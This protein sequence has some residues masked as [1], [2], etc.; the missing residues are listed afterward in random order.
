MEGFPRCRRCD[1][2]NLVPLSDFGGQGAAIHYKA[3]A[4]TRIGCTSSSL[5][6][7][8][9]EAVHRRADPERRRP[10]RRG[11]APLELAGRTSSSRTA[12]AEPGRFPVST[13]PCR[14]A[15]QLLRAVRQLLSHVVDRFC[16]RGTSEGTAP[17]SIAR[18]FGWRVG[19]GP[20]A[21]G[22]QLLAQLLAGAGPVT[23]I[24][25]SS[26]GAARASGSSSARSRD[27]DLLAH[28]QEEDLPP[29]RSR[30][31][32]D[33]A[34]GLRDP[35]EVAH[36]SGSRDRDRAAHVDLPREGRDHAAPAGQ[37]VAEP[38]RG[39]QRAS[40][41]AGRARHRLAA[42][43]CRLV[44]PITLV[45]STALSLETST[46]LLDAVLAGR[47]EH[48]QRCRRRSRGPPLRDT[49]PSA[50]RACRRR[51]GRR[52]AAATGAKTRVHLPDVGDVAEQTPDGPVAVGRAPVE[53]ADRAGRTR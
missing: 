21:A 10:T 32:D 23:T 52:L 17:A 1:D 28:V 22:H 14:F 13:S 40:P 46:T 27:V 16:E 11:S 3:W 15:S 7:R 43:R 48:V 20:F 18:I 44:A 41:G 30:R 39:E 34:G 8:N 42:R 12:E 25:M 50:G 9:G 26:A 5:K 49:P 2:G 51:R 24:G 31:L 6:I 53:G 19:D 37:D 45:G 4:C 29:S 36:M 38:D 47:V 33:Q 35:H